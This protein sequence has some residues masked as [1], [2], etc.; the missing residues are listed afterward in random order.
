MSY[1]DTYF[2]T[3]VNSSDVIGWINKYNGNILYCSSRMLFMGKAQAINFPEDSL[4]PGDAVFAP[5]GPYTSEDDPMVNILPTDPTYFSEPNNKPFMGLL[6]DSGY[7]GKTQSTY[8]SNDK[9]LKDRL[10]YGFYGVQ[11]IQHSKYIFTKA[12]VKRTPPSEGVVLAE[13]EL[14]AGY[15]TNDYLEIGIFL[16]DNQILIR[17]KLK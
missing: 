2:L 8:V 12:F 14:P 10:R 13:Y 15:S 17:P 9:Y 11:K 3:P 4:E 16:P 5:V 6:L 7:R 1:L